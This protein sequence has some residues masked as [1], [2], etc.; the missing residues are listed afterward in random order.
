MVI[1]PRHPNRLGDILS[2]IPLSGINISIRSKKEKIRNSSQ[3]Y[4][5][6]TIGEMDSLIIKSPAIGTSATAVPLAME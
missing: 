5:A 4:I 2:D 6:D 1:A 3:I